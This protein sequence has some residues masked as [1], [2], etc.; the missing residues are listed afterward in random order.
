[1]LRMCYDAYHSSLVAMFL[2]FMAGNTSVHLAALCPMN[3]YHLDCFVEIESE[4]EFRFLTV[5]GFPALFCFLSECLLTI[6][7]SAYL[8]HPVY[9]TFL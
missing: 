6:L 2:P 7:S 8:Y 5:L 9:D 1:M 3:V 4:V